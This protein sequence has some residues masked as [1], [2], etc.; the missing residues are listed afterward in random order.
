MEKR[1]KKIKKTE[2]KK[3]K[4]LRKDIQDGEELHGQFEIVKQKNMEDYDINSLA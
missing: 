1:R 2:K 4:K 3:Q